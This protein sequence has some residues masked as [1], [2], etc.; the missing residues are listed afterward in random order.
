MSE[1]GHACQKLNIVLVYRLTGE[2]A[3]KY[4]NK[5]YT[6]LVYGHVSISRSQIRNCDF[7]LIV[8]L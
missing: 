4:V 5:S 1:F 7:G 8:S 3:T 6:I 2:C